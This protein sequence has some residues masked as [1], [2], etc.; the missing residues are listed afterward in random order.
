MKTRTPHLLAA[1]AMLASAIASVSGPAL[2]QKPPAAIASIKPI[3]SLLAGVMEGVATPDIIVDG[4]ASP[5]AYALKPSQARSLQ[6][7]DLV[8]WV[9]HELEAFLEKPL[10][11]LAGQAAIVELMEAEGLTKL[12]YRED[13]AFEADDEEPAEEAAHDGHDHHDGVDPHLWLDPE[14]ARVFIREMA[15]ALG[16]ADPA[17]AA[18][19]AANANTLGR[20]LDGL[21]GE[22]EATL[23]PVK[24]KP[25]VVFHDAYHYFENR[26]GVVAAGSVTLSPEVAPGAERLVQLR[27]K[28]REL[29]AVCVFAEPQF[30]PRLMSVAT[31]GTDARSATLDPL[32]AEIENGPDLYFTLLKTMTEAL[33]NCLARA[34]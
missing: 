28:I 23:A 26:F 11:T 1:A 2:A 32:G 9:G 13:G 25:F 21:I 15:A 3:H 24:G 10:E 34:D 16:K 5:H 4:A 27:G 30:E 31:E 12:D 8:F 6:R 18:R 14:N 33:K 7:A 17:N 29:G 19:Y 20:R 22:I